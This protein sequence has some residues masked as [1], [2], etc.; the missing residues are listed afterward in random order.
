MDGVG[1]IGSSG[2]ANGIFSTF[3]SGL[4][5]LGWMR[6]VC[7]IWCRVGWAHLPKHNYQG[8]T[9]EFAFMSMYDTTIVLFSAK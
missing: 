7:H 2:L 6:L 4:V 5:G 1:W 9:T 3:S 8:M